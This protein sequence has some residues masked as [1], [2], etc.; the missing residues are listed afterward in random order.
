MLDL[1]TRHR[2]A[3][4]RGKLRVYKQQLAAGYQKLN[5]LF[6][7]PRLDA[8]LSAMVM[9]K[10]IGRMRAYQRVRTTM[11]PMGLHREY[12][13]LETRSPLLVWSA[14]KPRA[15]VTYPDRDRDDIDPLDI[16]NC[17]TVNYVL[18]GQLE[19]GHVGLAE[20]LWSLELQDH[21]LGRLIERNAGGSD[22]T[23]CILQ[24]HRA[25]LRISATLVV[26]HY[27][28]ERDLVLPAGPGAF[29]CTIRFGNDMM[30]N[31]ETMLHLI[32]RTWVSVGQLHSSQ[33]VLPVSQNDPLKDSLLLPQP[34]RTVALAS[35]DNGHNK[36]KV[37]AWRLLPPPWRSR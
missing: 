1:A 11:E 31:D 34:L 6:D 19:P 22:L 35:D 20:G 14:L 28:A 15:S 3:E 12:C 32:A 4:A 10:N 26:E 17:V 21:A 13:D 5:R 7:N 9:K 36:L 25:L 33:R 37:D 16:Q 2:N 18:A 24:A 8:D 27:K 29:I 30:Q 23:D